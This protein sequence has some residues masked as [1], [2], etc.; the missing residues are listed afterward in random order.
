MSLLIASPVYGQTIRIVNP[1][2]RTVFDVGEPVD[3]TGIRVE[4]TDDNGETDVVGD[5][6][7]TYAG[8]D[9]QQIG[10]QT[11]VVQYQSSSVPIKVMVQEGKIQSIQASLVPKDLWTGGTKLKESDF[12]V[13]AYEDTGK[14]QQ[15]SGFTFEPKILQSGHNV[16]RVSYNGKQDT[17][18]VT[19]K[20]NTVQSLR[21]ESPGVGE[22]DVGEPFRWS[23]LKVMA[24]YL[25][26]TEYDV[27]SACSVKGVDT[28]KIGTYNAVVTYIDKT[29]TYPVTV[30][31]LT[32]KDMEIINDNTVDL[33]FMERSDPITC[34]EVR[35]D[36]DWE[37]NI[38]TYYAVYKNVTYTKDVPIPE[39]E[40]KVV[41][42][43][44]ITAQVPV[45]IYVRTGDTGL[46]GYIPK[47]E[48][49]SRC[50]A[51]IKLSI[52]VAEDVPQLSGLPTSIV[53]PNSLVL[54]MP[55]ISTE[56]KF[57][58]FNTVLEV[59]K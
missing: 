11:I 30:S 5:K 25:D 6:D 13:I 41:G 18:T 12:K 37:N 16:I 35:V 24:V 8:Y 54:D 43:R 1:P 32:Y 57:Y 23:G 45:G 17:V 55:R 38:R 40:R 21:I 15:V 4:V 22:F 59:I 2:Q 52:S 39:N 10:E 29:A 51:N 3:L 56:E 34:T 19:A 53:L 7:L 46:T 48:L 20:E 49:Q 47:T 26:G 28:S 14:Q 36:N 31:K 42:S 9:P 44:H 33:Y 50:D 58:R 27:T